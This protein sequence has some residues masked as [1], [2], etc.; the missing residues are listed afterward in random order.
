[1][2]DENETLFPDDFGSDFVGD[3]VERPEAA[4]L[5]ATG[6]VLIGRYLG[7]RAIKTQKRPKGAQIHLF[8]EVQIRFT[9]DEER[10]DQKHEVMELW[11]SA[12]LDG[13][14]A[15]VPIGATVLCR[16][17]A[18]TE[19][20]GA[21]TMVLYDVMHDKRKPINDRDAIGRPE[22]MPW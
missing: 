9:H 19:K 21:G 2:S 17:T 16:R 15:R 6:D 4:G 11:G 3:V 10:R 1:M 18:G 13:K 22:K 5:N 20:V 12:D 7:F 8:A 14:L